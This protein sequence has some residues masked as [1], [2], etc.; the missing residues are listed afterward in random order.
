MRYGAEPFFQYSL[1]PGHFAQKY[2]LISGSCKPDIKQ[3]ND[4]GLAWLDS[5]QRFVQ[6][7]RLGIQHRLATGALVT[8]AILRVLLVPRV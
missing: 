5:S 1:G 3:L 6:Q 2:V 8:A 7:P 4:S